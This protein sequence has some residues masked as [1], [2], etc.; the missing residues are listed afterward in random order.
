MKKNV[1]YYFESDYCCCRC[2]CR[3]GRCAG[4]N[5]VIDYLINRYIYE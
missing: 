2:D 3:S 5:L 4:S 1:E